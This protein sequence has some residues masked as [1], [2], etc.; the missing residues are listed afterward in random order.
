MVRREG[1]E[2]RW[3]SHTHANACNGDGQ[4][5]NGKHLTLWRT[6]NIPAPTP[7]KPPMNATTSRVLSGILRQRFAA[8]SLSQTV[9]ANPPALSQAAIIIANEWCCK[10]IS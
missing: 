8:A 4:L 7:G 5:M 2:Q 1:S 10:S 6:R 9:S 3:S